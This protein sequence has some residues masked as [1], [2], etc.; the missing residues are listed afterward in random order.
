M[1]YLIILFKNKE[2]R[3]IINKFKTK[4]KALDFFNEQSKL[5][6]SV[7]FE[8]RTENGSKCQFEL[9]LME[10]KEFG[11]EKIYIKDELGRTTKV[12]TDSEEYNVLKIIKYNLEEEFLDYSTKKKITSNIFEKKYLSYKGIKMISKL[13]NKM[14]FQGNEEI[15]LFTFKDEDDA[16]RFIDSMENKM[17]SEKRGDCIFVKDFS[18]PQKKYLYNL[19]VEYGFPKSYLQRYSTTH[20]SKK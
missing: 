5:S 8:K 2:K 1:N 16:D 17:R 20:P 14:I 10:N 13:N 7:V 19:L 11:L 6:D 4:K 18:F 3:K 12:E 9:L 15:K